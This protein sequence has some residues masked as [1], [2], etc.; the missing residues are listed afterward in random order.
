MDQNIQKHLAFVTAVEYDSLTRAAEALGFSQSAISRMISDL[1]REWGIVLLRRDRTGV[2]LTAE[3]AEVLPT[4]RALCAAYQAVRQRVD[5]VRG[6][7]TGKVR[8]G[9]I[10]SIATH[11]LPAIIKAFRTDY[12]GIDYE[13]LL[14]DYSD[15]ERWLNEGR[16]DCGFLRKPCSKAFS[17]VPFERDEF[18]AIL[19]MGHRLSDLVA[20]PRAALC[21]E[22]FMALEHDGDT[23][24]AQIFASAGLRPHVDLSTW[25]DYAIMAMVECNL[26]LAVLPSLILKRTP[27]KIVSK[28]L[29]PPAFREIVF[30]TRADMEPSRSVERLIEYLPIRA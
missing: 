21:E 7:E 26:G 23:E 3:G 16:V 22:P 29:S 12:P 28:P 9:T 20:V 27:Y 19:P 8:I 13:L 17:T 1:E 6:L 14:G 4:S 11:R 24:V 18:L 2:R 15:I 5:E 25:D 10:S 30:A